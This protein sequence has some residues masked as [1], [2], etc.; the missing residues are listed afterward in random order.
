MSELATQRIALTFESAGETIIGRREHNE[1]ALLVRTDLDLYLLADGAGGH[2]A[3]NVASA[4]ATTA[5]AHYF[6]ETATDALHSPERDELG[7][8]ATGR[9]LACAV[10]QANREVI[11][12]AKTNDRYR[13]MGTTVVVAAVEQARGN[14][15]VAHVGDSRCYRLRRGQFELLTKDHSLINDVL[16]MRPD[17]GPSHAARLP[18][19]V[20]TSALGMGETVRVSVG[21]HKVLPGD[22]YLLCSDG[23]TDTLEDDLICDAMMITPAPEEQIRILLELATDVGAMDNVAA[24]VVHANRAPGASEPPRRVPNLTRPKRKATQEAY[25]ADHSFPEIVI[26]DEI[27]DDDGFPQIHVVPTD[28]ADLVSFDA[29]HGVSHRSKTPEGGEGGEGGEA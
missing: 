1:D 24:I 25:P 9:R 23:L 27:E 7:L 6:E 22:R 5:I 29:I 18:R 12:V 14:L 8:Y 28:A 20:I 26:L 13:G 15:H 2:N 3:G 10:Q 21:T 16:E 4:L 19:S 11:E 17:I